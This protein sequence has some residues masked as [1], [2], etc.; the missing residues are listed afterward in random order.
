[1]V[2]RWLMAVSAVMTQQLKV[3]VGIASDGTSWRSLPHLATQGR[4]RLPPAADNGHRT[5]EFRD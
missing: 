2:L 4:V 5:T 3:S 1:M